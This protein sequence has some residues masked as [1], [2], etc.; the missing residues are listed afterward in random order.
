MKLSDAVDEPRERPHSCEAPGCETTVPYDDE[1]YCLEHSA[2]SGSYVR[3][4]PTGAAACRPPA[5]AP[6]SGGRM[7]GVST[8]SAED[9]LALANMVANARLERQELPAAY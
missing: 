2:D 4:I 6:D 8:L 7:G 5:S 3:A 9:R 1:P